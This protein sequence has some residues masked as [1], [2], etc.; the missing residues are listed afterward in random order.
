MSCR[1]SRTQ[2]WLCLLNVAQNCN[3]FLF[4]VK[5]EVRMESNERMNKPSAVVL[6]SWPSSCLWVQLACTPER[7]FCCDLLAI[8][9]PSGSGPLVSGIQKSVRS[10]LPGITLIKHSIV[11]TPSQRWISSAYWYLGHTGM[12]K[13][14]G[15]RKIEDERYPSAFH[16]DRLM[17][18]MDLESFQY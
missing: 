11:A 12:R 2:M 13:G 16:A 18:N 6:L 17:R 15:R 3:A 4:G 1:L 10:S 7:W 8:P 9:W 5:S 14:K